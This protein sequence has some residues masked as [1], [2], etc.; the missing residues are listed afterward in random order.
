MRGWFVRRARAGNAKLRARFKGSIPLVFLT[1]IC[2]FKMLASMNRMASGRNRSFAFAPA[3]LI[4]HLA[5]GDGSSSVDVIGAMFRSEQNRLKP[6]L[7]HH[8]AKV[9]EPKKW[10]KR[11][12]HDD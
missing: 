3:E 9:P 7:A 4:K 8:Q 1:K 6:S 10:N 11:D 12:K 5:T 2:V